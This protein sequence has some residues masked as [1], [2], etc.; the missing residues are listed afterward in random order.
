MS[1]DDEIV[2]VNEYRLAAS[3][4]DFVAAIEALATD[5]ARFD[6]MLTEMFHG[7]R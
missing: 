6:L 4:D 3:A 7:T 5:T 2:N 1:I